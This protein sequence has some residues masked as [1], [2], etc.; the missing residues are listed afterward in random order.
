MT[1]DQQWQL[2]ESL[3]YE[4]SPRS[5][6]VGGLL[7]LLQMLLVNVKPVTSQPICDLR[8]LENYIKSAVDEENIMNDSCQFPEDVVVPEPGMNMEWRKLQTSQ[9][10]AEVHHGLTLL[11]NAVP[12]ITGFI[13]ECHL[14]L[15]LQKFSSKART[16]KNILERVINLKSLK[17]KEFRNC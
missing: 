15:S 16:M 14:Q 6:G 8:T 10:K 1:T 3:S 2:N 17:I 11:I 5:S 7:I 13:S 4:L 12:K 9:K